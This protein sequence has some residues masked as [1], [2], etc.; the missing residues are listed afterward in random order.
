MVPSLLH[1]SSL[2]LAGPAAAQLFTA[3]AVLNAAANAAATTGAGYSACVTAAGAIDYCSS[4]IP[5]FDNA[6]ATEVAQCLCCSS[7][8]YD[9]SFFDGYAQT[10]ATYVK[11]ALPASTDL[12]SAYSSLG[13]FCEVEGNVCAGGG[14]GGVTAT[15]TATAKTSQPTITEAATVPAACSTVLSILSFCADGDTAFLELPIQTQAE[16]YCYLSDTI[17]HTITW[18]PDLF[19]GYGSQCAQWAKTA[20]P[21]DYSALAVYGTVCSALG[22]FLET[23][24]AGGVTTT[25]GSA[26][27]TSGGAGG[28][29][30]TSTTGKITSTTAKSTATVT[31]SPTTTSSKNA[32]N[33][34]HEQSSI[35][36]GLGAFVM[37]L[38]LF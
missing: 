37:G 5:D 14:G 2:L 33:N 25:K 26:S 35:I 23:T 10:C 9:P 24:D 15:P 29:L 3:P 17:A 36:A 7:T 34:L 8:A 6:P 28:L 4:A 11:T 20:D 18:A 31:V 38:F 30:G 16:C 1:F 27:K 13:S 19:D 32:A 12:Y 22:D 21:T